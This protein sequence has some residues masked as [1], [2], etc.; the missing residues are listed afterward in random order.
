MAMILQRLSSVKLEK[1]QIGVI[2]GAPFVI[3][4]GSI[5]AKKIFSGKEKGKMIDSLT[6]TQKLVLSKEAVAHKEEGNNFYR[7]EKFQEA[8][9]CYDKALEKCPKDQLI[10][11]AMLLHNRAA[12]FE[13]L[14][15]WDKVL[16]DSNESLKYSPRY[17]K[18]Y[19]RR[20]RAHEALGNM[21][22]SLDDITACC[23]L[24]MFQNNHSIVFADRILKLTAH[25]DAAAEIANRPPI[26]PSLFAVNSYMR[27]FI[28][29]PIQ[30]ISVPL[31]SL[32]QTPK[33]FVR[34]QRALRERNFA[35]II[36]GCKEE[37]ESLEGVRYRPEALLMLGTFHLLSN[38][39]AESK[40]EF[41][42]IIANASTD[43]KLRAYAH[44]RRATVHSHLN[45]KAAAEADFD[46][47]KQLQPKN[48]D[49]YFQRALVLM[50]HEH[51]DAALALYEKAVA[52]APHHAL[53]VVKKCYVEYRATLIATDNSNEQ[54]NEDVLR[55]F[56]EAIEKFPD[57]VES[58]SLMAQVLADQQDFA[59]ANEYYEMAL[60]LEPC[61][62]SVI[63]EH[64][65]MVMQWRGDKEMAAEMLNRAIVVDRQ[66][67]QAYETLGTIEVQRARLH[68][69]VVQFN[70]AIDCCKSYE[71]LV[72]AFALRN[73]A[74][75]QI[76]V[77]NKLDID[78]EGMTELV[79]QRRPQPATL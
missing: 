34:A 31:R 45:D 61:N 15:Q 48:P 39:F 9:Q 47:A 53:A 26:V 79:Q 65:L 55:R 57:C 33:G 7:N 13:M 18:A 78:I 51:S 44:I 6:P 64:A 60:E 63:V 32:S 73:A 25:A 10:D 28:N 20:A 22:A 42:A 3:G 19:I 68:P 62:P 56:V 21:K 30:T 75:A 14:Q 17:F 4:L 67:Q 43:A 38:A 76:N 58:Y 70:K 59:K 8:V 5:A 66:C 52:L 40:R 77:T 49:V 71:E 74:Q 29:D 35:D 37:I 36:Q 50:P 11:M 46:A 12:A 72:H 2:C 16:Q 41:E 54:R 24:E 23:I 69:A 27:S 1:W